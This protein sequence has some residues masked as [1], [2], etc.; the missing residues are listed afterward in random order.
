MPNSGSAFTTIGGKNDVVTPE[1]KF[2]SNTADSSGGAIYG[3]NSLVIENT[4]FDGNES[5]GGDGGGAIVAYSTTVTLN[6]V[7]FRNNVCADYGAAIYLTGSNGSESTLELT[8]K[9]VIFEDNT[10]SS[11]AG[12]MYLG[13]GVR[14]YMEDAQFLRNS[15]TYGGAIFCSGATLE[16]NRATFTDNHAANNAGAVGVYASSNVRMNAITATG[17]TAGS[18]GAFGYCK[19][20]NLAVY[21]SLFQENVSSGAAGAWYLAAGAATQFYGTTFRDNS[22]A[23]NAGAISIYSGADVEVLIHSCTFDGNSNNGSNTTGFGGALHIS[24]A[25]QVKL[26]NI[27]ATDNEGGKGGF[28]YETTAGTNVTLVGLTVSGNTAREGGPVIWGNTFNAKLFID[29]DKYTDLDHTGAYDDAYWA[30]AIVNKLTVEEISQQIPK[31]LDYGNEPYDH[32]IEA[33]D[34]A[35]AQQL[36]DAL[37]AETRYIRV[38]ADFQIDRTFYITK[39]TTIFSTITRTLTRSPNFAGDIF[40]VG[41]YADGTNALIQ[42]GK[43]K[44][45]LGNPQSAQSDLLIIDGNK[46]NMAVDVV[47]SVVF[48]CNSSSLDLH[49]NMTIRNCFKPGNERTMIARYGVKVGNRMGGSVIMNTSGTVNIYGGLY[50]NN[51]IREEIIAEDA[52]DDSGR[53]STVGGVILNRGTLQIHGGRFV[54]NQ[55]ARGGVIYNYYITEITGGSFIGNKAT[56]SGGVVY[57]A[58]SSAAHLRIGSPDGLE[59]KILFENNSAT[60]T[61]GVVYGAT[62]SVLV[63]YG[64]A[65]FIGNSATN[66]GALATYGQLTVRNAQ[67]L[68]NTA[69]NRGG[70]IYL[71]KSV[72]NYTSRLG[73]V[74]NCSFEG[75]K[76]YLGGA[77]STYASGEDFPDGTNLTVKNTSFVNNLASRQTEDS[78]IGHGGAIY[79]TRSTTLTVEDSTF[80]GNHAETEAGAIYSAFNSKVY[81]SGSEIR[82]SSS[83]KYGGALSLRSVTAQIRDTQIT[84]AT[85][86]NNGG[87]IYVSYNSASLQNTDLTIADCV[88][89]QTE[90]QNNGGVIYATRHAVEKEHRILTVLNT[91]ISDA[92]AAEAGGAFYLQTGVEAVMNEVTADTCSAGKAGGFLYTAGGSLKLYNS[93]L[94]NC[95]SGTTGGALALYEGTTAGIYTTS[96]TGNTATSNGGAAMVYTDGGEVTFHSCDFVNNTAENVGGVMYVSKKSQLNLYNTTATGN[97]AV[98]GGFLYVTTTGTVV[99]L[100][101]TTISGNT[102][103]EAAPII[104]GN[105][106]GAKLKLNKSNFVDSDA[107]SALDEAYWAAAIVNLLTVEEIS[108]AIPPCEEYKDT[109]TGTTKPKT[110]VPVDD[111]LNLGL[112][113]SD[114]YINATY[115]AFPRLDNSSNFMSRNTTTFENVNGGDV[116]VDSFIYYMNEPAHNGTVGLG[117]LIYQAILYKQANPEE[118]VYIDTSFYRFSVQA[119]VNINRNSRYFGYA[120][121]LPAGKEYDQYGF[122][123]ISY[124]LVTAAKMGIHVT[125]MGQRDGYPIVGNDPDLITYFNRHMTD[126]CDANYVENAVVSDYLKF[127]SCDWT[128]GESKGGTDMMHLKICTVSHYLDMNGVAHRNAVFTSSS[129]LDGINTK[130]ANACVAMQTS[131]IVSDHADIYRTAVNYVRLVHDYAAQ[132]QIYEFQDLVNERSAQQI[133][134]I[135]A[136]NGDQIPADQQLVYLGSETDQVFELYFTP[137]GGDTLVWSDRYNPY[138]KYLQKMYDSEDYI[139]FTWNAAQYNGGYALGQQMEQMISAAFHDNANVNNR[140]YFNLEHFDLALLSD[141]KV[142]ET[143]GVKTLNK[144]NY[145]TIHS[146]DVQVSYVEDGQRYY[147]SLLN[148]LNIHSGSMYYQSNF[149]LVVKE[150]ELT[151]ESVFFTLADLTTKNIVEHKYGERQTYLPEDGTHGYYYQECEECGKILEQG[152]AHIPGQW[153]TD[154]EPTQVTKGIQ[155]K[156]CVVCKCLIM[157]R[158]IGYT[159]ST[160]YDFSQLEGRTFSADPSSMVQVP[161]IPTPKTIEALI[162]MPKSIS[163]RGGVVVG[164]YGPWGANAVNLEVYSNGNVRLYVCNGGVTVSQIFDVDVRSDGVTHIALTVDGTKAILYINGTFARAAELSVTLPEGIDGFQIGGDNREDNTQYFKG[165]IHA[166]NLFDEVRTPDQIR[167][168]AI[169]VAEGEENLIYSNYFAKKQTTSNNYQEAA[170]VDKIFTAQ[171]LHKIDKVFNA[172][173]Q[174][175]EAL[176][177]TGTGKEVTGVIVGNYSEEAQSYLNLEL[178]EGGRVRLVTESVDCVFDADI[179]SEEYVHVAVTVNG[180]VAQLYV[181]GQLVQ[182]K[183]LEAKLGKAYKGFVVGGDNR[184][185]NTAYFQ[186]SIYSVSLFRDVRTAEEINKDRILVSPST[187]GLLYT[188]SFLYDT[189]KEI[190]GKTFTADQQHSVPTLAAAPKT[191]EAVIQMPKVFN[192]RGGVILGSYGGNWQNAL[193]IEVYYNGLVRVYTISNGKSISTLFGV[194]VR[195]GEKTHLA[196]T[197]DGTAVTLFVNGQKLETKQLTTLTPEVTKKLLVGGDHR[198]GNDQ[199]FKG[200]IYSIGLYSQVRTEEEILSNAQ[201]MSAVNG[202]DLYAEDFAAQADRHKGE[203][204]TIDG[205]RFS[206]TGGYRAEELNST[207][208]T[209]EALV[210]LPAYRYD[211]SG[212]IVGNFKNGG[213]NALNLEIYYAGKIRLYYMNDGVCVDHL[214]TKSVYSGGLRHIAVTVSGLTATLY[215]DGEAVETAQLPVGLPA[216]TNNFVVG[217][218]NRPN[219]SQYFK[220]TIYGVKLYADVRTPEE[221]WKD[222][223]GVAAD[224]QDLLFSRIFTQGEAVGEG[225]TFH[226]TSSFSVDVL[227]KTPSTLEATIRLSETVSGR[228]GVIVGNYGSTGPQMN[229]E[230]YSRGRVRLYVETEDITGQCFFE[231][232]IRSENVRHIA[233]TVRG[234]S[235]KLYI[236]GELKESAWIRMLPIDCTQNF[237]IGSDNREGNAQYFKGTIYNVSLFGD[238]RTAEEIRQDAKGVAADAQD[239]LFT[240]SFTGNECPGSIDGAHTPGDWQVVRQATETEEGL[241]HRNCSVCGKLLEVHQIGRIVADGGQ[242]N[243]SNA[244]LTFRATDPVMKLDE[245]MK[246]APVTFEFML[247]LPKTFNNRAGVVFGNYTGG[248]EDQIN[249]EIYND[250]RPRVYFRNKSVSIAY[251]FKTD[252]RSDS[253]V[254]VAIVAEGTTAKLYLNGEFVESK[255][256]VTT[257]PAA[258]SG[259]CIGGDNRLNNEQYFRGSLYAINI[260][261]DVRTP[262]EIQRDMIYVPEDTSGLVY[263]QYFVQQ[264]SDQ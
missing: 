5:K 69:V 88:I 19:E 50:E 171:T 21:N 184:E 141:L 58:N 217:G 225:M 183:K 233:V 204:Q 70:A 17:N 203:L 93:S 169:L 212:V 261:E 110:P 168:D 155:H 18:N 117:L 7:T 39:E 48:L 66:G 4:V 214:F 130:G 32:M 224:A 122:V 101:G 22:A 246:G 112:N 128:I 154:A 24:G 160:S 219:N 28:M 94:S 156:E 15:G 11:Y 46:D 202:A 216:V 81:I 38:V 258:V 255:E 191:I 148:S 3:R 215:I 59:E 263:S 89:S 247:Q 64:D 173:P 83:G 31:Y 198:S 209:L 144:W 99:V 84:G 195:S 259:Y 229:L 67:F 181:D 6:N 207:P 137:F 199:Y 14:A 30:A 57:Q 211:R 63:V 190:P 85:A 189:Q 43:V 185:G 111:V 8:A 47:G 82:D 27:T 208:H 252:I 52:M 161:A 241:K 26:Y 256:M 41:E 239:L 223:K 152:V 248:K 29:K 165:I 61:G 257:L 188:G 1:V 86:A 213:E 164:N 222:A 170:P 236:D 179:R 134:M 90:S 10:A 76:A 147:V 162:H 114:E 194:D 238:V 71:S 193:N 260:F 131:T 196:V 201:Q 2:E 158:E 102:A 227:A 253:M 42:N 192:D 180:I 16:M 109:E 72:I 98:K 33:T 210:Q 254:H 96:F 60:S 264:D 244:P 172:T 234:N 175:I 91:T 118:D 176:I 237:M 123:R 186:G 87:A 145:G 34:V 107:Q 138:C 62:L 230:V 221:V 150:T 36:E 142:G 108:D 65:Q 178:C 25:S 20:S 232:D 56:K 140:I 157:S 95:S 231:T 249:I 174:T 167:M 125:A 220:G 97:T 119:G 54:N 121:Q 92:T 133:D 74:V 146:K 151:E 143:I 262:E 126:P 13:E 250:G 35:N 187:H 45:T 240:R 79:T 226:K 153:I 159:E 73:T 135:L 163:D 127:T 136:G 40:V 53:D 245:D 200:T 182:T 103:T 12:A 55:G 124:L 78:L 113:S 49:E 23:T 115:D 166:I 132:E 177:R 51:G 37:K 106:T 228:G 80:T 139:W 68:E 205:W 100:N 120:R 77:I 44:L 197:L 206:E 243:Y 235:A 105:S 116:S 149:M 129:N 75:N 251:V 9:N 218:D 104:W 242:V